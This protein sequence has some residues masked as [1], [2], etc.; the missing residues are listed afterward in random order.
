MPLFFNFDQ[1][2]GYFFL[3]LYKFNQLLNFFIRCVEPSFLL[4]LSYQKDI[5]RLIKL[6]MQED[7]EEDAVNQILQVQYRQ[8]D[9]EALYRIS[10]S[11]QSKR[12]LKSI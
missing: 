2:S 3:L 10:S 9:T 12:D 1:M 5:Q 4:D 7:G 11:A 6:Y 8:R